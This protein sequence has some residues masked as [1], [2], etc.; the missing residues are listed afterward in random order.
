MDFE[1]SWE[2]ARSG[3]HQALVVV[4]GCVWG[5]GVVGGET[6]CRRQDTRYKEQDTGKRKLIQDA[7][8][9]TKRDAGTRL[10]RI[11]DAGYK[12]VLHSLVAPR[13]PAD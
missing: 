5:C 4:M 6:I 2:R 12:A 1:V 11:Q 13:G 9:F 10:Q 8:K 3:R 7:A